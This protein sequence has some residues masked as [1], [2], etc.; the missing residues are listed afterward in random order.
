MNR[1]AWWQYTL[2]VILIALG[3]IYALPNLYGS[4]PAIQISLKNGATMPSDFVSIVSNDLKVAHLSVM[5]AV[6]SDQSVLIRFEDINEQLK[7]LDYLKATFDQ[8]HYTISPNI[9]QSTPA[10]L[11]AI[12]AKQMTKGLDLQG[13]IHFLEQVETDTLISNHTLNDSQAMASQLRDNQIRYTSIHPLNNTAIIISFLDAKAYSNGMNF[14]QSQFSDYQWDKVKTNTAVPQLKG[15]LSD[16]A[17]ATLISNA[18]A[19]NMAILRE[20]VNEL[21]VSEPVV[22]QQGVDQ[23]S[24]DL[25]GIQDAARAKELIGKVATISMYMVDMD[26]YPYVPSSPNETPIGTTI[27]QTQSGEPIVLKNQVVLSGGAITSATAQMSQD[28]ATPEVAVTVAGSAQSLFNRLTA[29]NIGKLMATVLTETQIETKIVDGKPTYST[30]Q[31][32]KVI[33][34]A[35]I[36][37]ALGNSFVITNLGSQQYAENL[38]LLLRSGAYSAP[39]VTVQERLVGPSL[40]KENIYRGEL[41]T[42]VGTLLVIFFMIVYYRFFGVV[43][44]LSL[45]LNLVLII[46]ILSFIGA[47]LTLPGIAAIVLTLGMA[48][49]ANVL[50]NERIREELRLGVTP[51]AAISAGYSRAF[52]TIVDANV[53]TLIVAVVLVTISSSSVKGFAVNLIIGLLTS[54]VTAIFFSRALINLIY[55]RRKYL[56]KLSIGI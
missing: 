42:V 53:T 50:I 29:Q 19:Q 24:V 13:G 47:T 15:T 46:A 22:F 34:Y 51:Q 35:T 25:P 6:Q 17:S 32:S 1:Y 52:M 21:G 23:I 26:H 20:R 55:G 36:N 27:Y 31:V 28:T 5:G 48:V 30:K 38:A 40:G 56:K 12:G 8:D 18:V 41:S 33:N 9:A 43:A 14:L 10:W 11:Q 4:N 49:D 39:L 7:A 54:M 44:S 16:A 3:V 2:I 45:L 37:S